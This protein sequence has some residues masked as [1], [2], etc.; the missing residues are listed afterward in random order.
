MYVYVYVLITMVHLAA[1]VMEGLCA[2]WQDAL[3]IKSLDKSLGYNTMKERLTRLWKLAAGFEIM[4]IGNDYYMVKFDTEA[5]C[6]KVREEGPWMIFDHYL[7][8][9]C[10]SSEF[11]SSMAKIDKTM[12]WIRFPSLN[13]F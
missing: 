4:D 6:M 1:S 5:D 13:L 2:P 10:W 7:T 9:Q 11:V 12:V 3:V 8:V